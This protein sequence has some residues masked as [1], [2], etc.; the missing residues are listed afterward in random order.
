MDP[1][2]DDGDLC[3]LD[4]VLL[5]DLGAHDLAQLLVLQLDHQLQQHLHARDRALGKGERQGWGG[6]TGGEL[7]LAA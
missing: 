4:L 7:R 2:G 5:L 6:E 1:G 3:G